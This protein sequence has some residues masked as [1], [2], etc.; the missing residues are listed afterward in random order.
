MEACEK[1]LGVIPCQFVVSGWRDG[2]RRR[3]GCGVPVAQPVGY[4]RAT[5]IS[6]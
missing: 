3:G 6:S 5:A 4:R 1:G 2:Q